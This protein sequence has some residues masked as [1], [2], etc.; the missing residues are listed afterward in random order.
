MANL[1]RAIDEG[2]KG[3]WATILD[4]YEFAPTRTSVDLKDKWRNMEKQAGV[5]GAGGFGSRR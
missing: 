2:L 1:K 5:G 3:H 4:T